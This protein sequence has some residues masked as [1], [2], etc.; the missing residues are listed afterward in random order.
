V[1]KIKDLG[2]KVIPEQMRP[3]ECLPYTAGCACTQFVT[4]QQ[5]ILHTTITLCYGC[6]HFITKFPCFTGTI[7]PC[8]GGTVITGT[9]GGSETPWTQP[10]GLTVEQVRTLREQLQQQVAALDEYAKSVGPKTAEEIDE[11]EKQL[12]EELSNLKARR[13]SLGK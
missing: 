10:G 11:R 3:A 6:T 9:C 2:I 13:K 5:C 12:N 8:T 7:V 1:P 4:Y